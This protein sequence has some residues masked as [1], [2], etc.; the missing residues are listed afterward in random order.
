MDPIPLTVETADRC[1]LAAHLHAATGPARAVA[2]MVPAMAVPKEFYSALGEWLAARGL[3]V[4]TFDFRGMGKSA[5]GSLRGFEADILTWA[6]Q[7]C[8]AMLAAARAR[9]AG[10]PVVWIGHSLGGQILAMTPGNA[11]LAAAVT[12]ASG[13]GYWRENAYPLR[14]YSWFLWFLAAPVATALCGYFPG[15]ILGMVGDLPRG[16]IE[17]WGRWCRHPEYAVG[18]EGEAMR[19]RYRQVRLPLLSLSFTDDEY[20]SER[21]VAVLHG[22]Y[23]NAR[24][25]MRRMTPRELGVSRIGHFGFFRP[26]AGERLWPVLLDWV[27]AALSAGPATR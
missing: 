13:V 27:E 11:D 7:D 15:R 14:L 25:D 9:A 3:D 26:R 10:R 20:M 2:L 22:F 12:V 21:N 8:A 18:V 24:R 23:E 16:V 17:Q 19:H 6:G 5:A 4:L 1:R